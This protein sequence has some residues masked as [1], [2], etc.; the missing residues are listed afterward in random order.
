MNK[1]TGMWDWP[2]PYGNEP[3]DYSK[4]EDYSERMNAIT[5]GVHYWMRALE[6][7]SKPKEI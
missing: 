5:I 7:E 6:I 4:I 2:L 1:E 3:D